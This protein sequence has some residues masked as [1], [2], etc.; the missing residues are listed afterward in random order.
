MPFR[1]GLSDADYLE[2]AKQRQSVLNT[3]NLEQ[4][5]ILDKNAYFVLYDQEDQFKYSNFDGNKI[6]QHFLILPLDDDFEPSHSVPLEEK[7]LFDIVQK[8]TSYCPNDYLL[9]WKSKGARSIRKWH[10]HILF[11]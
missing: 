4:S 3:Q 9:F 5:R 2:L 1:K 7:A 10:A 11:I 6:E 8:A